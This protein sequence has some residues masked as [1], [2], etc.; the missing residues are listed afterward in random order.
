MLRAMTMTTSQTALRISL[1]AVG[2]LALGAATVAGYLAWASW[3]SSPIAGCGEQSLFDCSA[4][5]SGKWSKWLGVPVS[6]LGAITYG[7]LFCVSLS[8]SVCQ[9]ARNSAWAWLLLALLGIL[10]AGAAVWFFVVQAWV[11]GEFC[12]YC[13][14][15]H[16]CGLAI[17]LLV[18]W[19]LPRSNREQQQARL[20][21][22]FGFQP[23]TADQPAGVAMAMI[24]SSQLLGTALLAVVGL[25]VLILGQWF[26]ADPSFVV[27]MT[28]PRTKTEQA[29][30]A[31]P[32]P[33]GS[34][35]GDA[36]FLESAMQFVPAEKAPSSKTSS[37]TSKP[38][39]QVEAGQPSGEAAAEKPLAAHQNF[40]PE[41][42]R[43]GPE[44]I[45][46]LLVDVQQLPVLGSP[47]AE[48]LLVEL[49]D[50][51]CPHCRHF[52][53]LMTRVLQRYGD[54]VAIVIRP[55]ALSPKCN[56][57]V[58]RKSREHAEACGYSK[59]ALAVW[60]MDHKKF[61]EFHNWLMGSEKIP[62]ISVAKKRAVRLVGENV[63][64]REIFGK[65]VQ[66]MLDRNNQI[67]HGTKKG[68]PTLIT[69]V[70]S[71]SGMPKSPEQL[72]AA[73][74]K[75]LGVRPMA[76]ADRPNAPTGHLEQEAGK[77]HPAVSEASNKP[78]PGGE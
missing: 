3:S 24:E 61:P 43:R 5:I 56:P 52:H 31:S 48:H 66:E 33:V 59:L 13:C 75:H 9:R 20:G 70:G 78:V 53:H 10:A 73:L 76:E 69:T 18:L 57:Y 4:V 19:I 60:R 58:T 34:T 62:S 74:E 49:L 45:G 55:V 29:G 21:M 42:V 51:T 63:L 16:I 30:T 25:G 37:K 71:I 64:L 32:M 77:N 35:E 15:I 50:Y 8:L 36:P 7:L 26:A 65:A 17:C 54:Q 28:T 22:V 12:L 39:Q 14:M 40:Q 38:R 68:L 6:L 2:V 41:P 27:Q 23:E 47:Q 1:G 72:F 67:L 44:M 11:L 46:G